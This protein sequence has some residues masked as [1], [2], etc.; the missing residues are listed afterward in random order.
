MTR[1]LSHPL[2]FIIH[3]TSQR[4]AYIVWATDLHSL[5][6]NNREDSNMKQNLN[7]WRPA[8]QRMRHT[9]E[10]RE[11]TICTCAHHNNFSYYLSEYWASDVACDV[12]KPFTFS[13]PTLV[14]LMSSKE[15][16]KL[17]ELVLRRQTDK[18]SG[19]LNGNGYKNWNLRLV[20]N[21]GMWRSKVSIYRSGETQ[22]VKADT[23]VACDSRAFKL[24]I[25][26]ILPFEVA[27]RA[28]LL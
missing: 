20:R 17:T 21:A 13:A 28:I 12:G 23:F 14:N 6:R 1:L 10:E 22:K 9:L 11:R 24:P 19:Y 4:P 27:E 16:V 25:M 7:G 15:E 8:T 18:R 3:P 2:K 26:K 5:S